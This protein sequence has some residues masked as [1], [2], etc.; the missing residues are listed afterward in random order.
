[1]VE[2]MRKGEIKRAQ[3]QLAYN[4]PVGPPRMAMATMDGLTVGSVFYLLIWLT[5]NASVRITAS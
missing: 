3:F 5:T 2:A 4:S 1:M